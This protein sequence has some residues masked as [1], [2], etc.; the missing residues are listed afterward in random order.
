MNK[1]SLVQST[2]SSIAAIESLK[3]Q[4]E[5]TTGSSI[6]NRDLGV[7]R[8]K[9]VLAIDCS[10]SMSGDPLDH[11]K[12]G[13]ISFAADA[14]R[15]GYQVGIVAFGCD[16]E[17]ITRGSLDQ[18]EI[19]RNLSRLAIMGS[20]NMA[21]ALRTAGEL[22]PRASQLK[23]ICL[24]TDGYPNDREET[25]MIAGHLKAQNIE[26]ITLGTEDA[27]HRFLAE[28][29]TRKELAVRGSIRTLALDMGRTALLLTAGR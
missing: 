22:L 27:D 12:E 1:S 19:A 8:A 9:A 21:A 29:A 25:M 2:G 17:I 7:G 24:V 23:A 18:P 5:K 16:S 13:A 15:K 20:T 4:F 6:T 26:I 10:A 11:A 28:L 14:I 3:A